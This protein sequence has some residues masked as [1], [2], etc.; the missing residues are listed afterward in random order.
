VKGKILLLTTLVVV[1]VLSLAASASAV[2][3]KKMYRAQL[4]ELNGSGV[5]GTVE[6]TILPQN[7]L[8]VKVFASG[9]VP[10]IMHGLHIHGFAD[11]TPSTMPP[12]EDMIYGDGITYLKE[13]I[14]YTGPSLLQCKPVPRADCYG[15][16]EYTR[17]FRSAEIADLDLKNVPLSNRAVMLR[18]GFVPATYYGPA[19]EQ[20]L[21]VA[22]GLFVGPFMVE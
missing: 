14:L 21:P 19:Y 3:M 17:V 22:V 15:V 7:Q 11:G 10:D 1:L 12:P 9:F 4:V 6:L 8:R 2:T 18:G 13:A 5:V 20:T 16:I